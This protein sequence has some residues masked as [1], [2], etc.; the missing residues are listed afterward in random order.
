[1]SSI[2]SIDDLTSDEQ[3]I[4]GGLVRLMVRTDGSFTEEEEEAI[5]AIGD[6]IGG[7]ERFWR[8]ISQSAQAFPDEGAIR[9]EVASLARADVRTFILES[10]KTIAEADQAEDAEDELIAWVAEQWA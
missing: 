2:S 5:N 8:M 1:V 6:A 9:S 4:F 10:L 7:H 3:L